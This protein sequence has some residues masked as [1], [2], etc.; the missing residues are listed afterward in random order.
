MKTCYVCKQEKDESMFGQRAPDA[1][2]R[3][4]YRS[5]CKECRLKAV[6]EL[7]ASQRSQPLT[8]ERKAKN[9]EYQRKHQAEKRRLA[10]L[11]R[12][13]EAMMKEQA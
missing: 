9:A 3:V 11:G 1:K 10:E 2:G 4:Y 8:P 5:S 6:R 7:K 12:K 13:Y